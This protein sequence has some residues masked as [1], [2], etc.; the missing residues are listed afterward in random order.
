[1][2][3]LPLHPL[4]VHFP[5]V[6]GVLLPFVGFIF[7]WGIKKEIVPQRVWVLVAALALIYSVSAL[8]ATELGERDEE[9]VEDVVSERVIEEHEEAGELVPW[10]AGTLFFVSL[11]GYLRQNSDRLR[12]TLA[13]LSLIAIFPLVQA[14]HTGGELVYK[15][16]AAIAHLPSKLQIKFNSGDFKLRTFKS[17]ENDKD[18]DRDKDKDH[19]KKED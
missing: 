1:M 15:Y 10:V 8:V 18:K 16:G 11:A 4:V 2:F 17:S 6:L 7:W 19:D 5:I 12:L 9:K 13:I 14:G 3:D